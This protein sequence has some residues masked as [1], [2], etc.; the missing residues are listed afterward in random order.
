MQCRLEYWNF[1][2]WREF[3]VCL[4]KKIYR[5]FVSFV[6]CQLINCSRNIWPIRKT[7]KGCEPAQEEGS[8]RE[9]ET[10]KH[11][12]NHT[13]WRDEKVYSKTSKTF[14]IRPHAAAFALS[15]RRP[16]SFCWILG[17]VMLMLLPVSKSRKLWQKVNHGKENFFFSP[18]NIIYRRWNK[19]HENHTKIF[20]NPIKYLITFTYK[21][22]GKNVL[23]K[24]MNNQVSSR[25]MY[26]DIL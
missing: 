14:P 12:Q 8:D 16:F 5:H 17:L 21:Y 3:Q 2:F 25:T 18:V 6:T 7:S 23:L 15:F 19:V 4:Q 10:E 13:L 11:T 22:A 24:K 9:K 26:T 1:V 20:S